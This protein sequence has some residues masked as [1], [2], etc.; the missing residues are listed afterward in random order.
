MQQVQSGNNKTQKC[1]SV[2]TTQEAETKQQE[3]HDS[4]ARSFRGL[5]EREEEKGGREK[6]GCFESRAGH[7]TV[8]QQLTPSPIRTS[9]C[10]DNTTDSLLQLPPP[11]NT[12]SKVS[13]ACW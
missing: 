3:N 10:T 9:P 13:V 11:W 12:L 2:E 5:R 6:V 4:A 8:T 1:A 7:V